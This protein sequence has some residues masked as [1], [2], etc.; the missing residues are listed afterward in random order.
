MDVWHAFDYMPL[1][2]ICGY[3]FVDRP[4]HNQKNFR[5]IWWDKLHSQL[6]MVPKRNGLILMGDF[7]CQLSQIPSQSGAPQ[8]HWNNEIQIGPLHSDQ[9][10]FARIIKDHALTSLATWNAKDGPSFAFD[11]HGSR[12]DHVFSSSNLRDAEAKHCK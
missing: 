1:D 5:S 12:I 10:D 9:T 6:Q 3:Q 7:N 8:F 11:G 4:T 2:V